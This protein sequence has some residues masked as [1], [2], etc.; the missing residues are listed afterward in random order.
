MCVDLW[1]WK[2]DILVLIWFRVVVVPIILGL[3]F[4][5]LISLSLPCTLSFFASR[6][7]IGFSGLMVVPIAPQTDSWFLVLEHRRTESELPHRNRFSDHLLNHLI[8]RLVGH[9]LEVIDVRRDDSIV[10][11]V[12]AYLTW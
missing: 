11:I 6:V 3:D 1:I 5:A 7:I 10:C 2:P 8:Q 9:R 12:K 4:L